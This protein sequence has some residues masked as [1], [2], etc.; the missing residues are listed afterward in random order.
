M[1]LLNSLNSLMV[2]N[3]KQFLKFQ[4][5]SCGWRKSSLHFSEMIFSMVS[6]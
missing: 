4:G 3:N 1:A 2:S 5:S 6:I